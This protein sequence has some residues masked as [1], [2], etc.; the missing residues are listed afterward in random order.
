MALTS[1]ATA[2]RCPS[3]GSN[4]L[5]GQSKATS[6]I[7][8]PTH[9]QLNSLGIII[10]PSEI[11]RSLLIDQAGAHYGTDRAMSD[12]NLQKLPLISRLNVSR[13]GLTLRVRDR[14]K[15]AATF[16]I[17]T[18]TEFSHRRTYKLDGI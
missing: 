8:D 13:R 16:R 1:L 12:E 2:I 17:A 4:G 15:P 3:R 9:K 14:L 18:R 7:Q 6:N 10:K 5:T 11:T